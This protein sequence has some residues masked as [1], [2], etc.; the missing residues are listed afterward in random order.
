MTILF[1]AQARE[2]AGCDRYDLKTERPLAAAELW[3]QLIADFP[4]LALL[5]KTA[6]LARGES[7]LQD[8]ELL[9]PSDEV[10]IIPPV[11]GG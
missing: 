3:A 2:A 8:G 4:R 7:Y 5:E 1:F 11:S 9:K 6:R 10:A